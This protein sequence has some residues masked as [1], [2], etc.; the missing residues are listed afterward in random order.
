MHPDWSK[1]ITPLVGAKQSLQDRTIQISTY[2]HL[3]RGG[4]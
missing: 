2:S 3:M 1:P 4:C